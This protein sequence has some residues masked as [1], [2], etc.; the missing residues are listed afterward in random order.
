MRKN[1]RGFT[2]LPLQKLYWILISLA[3]LVLLQSVEVMIRVKD[4][5]VFEQWLEG[6]KDLF[7]MTQSREELFRIYVTSNLS[8][9]FMKIIIP[10]GLAIHSYLAYSRLRVNGLF[11]FIWLTLILG[12]A[13]YTLV[14]MQSNNLFFFLYILIYSIV[15]FVLLSIQTD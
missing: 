2:K 13:A 3:V 5:L 14:G 6:N 8:L 1:M 12:S 9:Y 4:V 15:T 10:I 7:E 11:R